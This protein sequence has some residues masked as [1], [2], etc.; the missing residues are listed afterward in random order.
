MSDEKYHLKYL[1]Y[2]T[3][4]LK[5]RLQNGSGG[6]S[7]EDFLK[8]IEKLKDSEEKKKWKELINNLKKI[9][10]DSLIDLLYNYFM[11]NRQIINKINYS[12]LITDDNILD[13]ELLK[14]LLTNEAD[15][16]IDGEEI[17]QIH[18][19]IRSLKKENIS[20]EELQQIYDDIK[21]EI[22]PDFN[23]KIIDLNSNKGMIFST[24]IEQIYQQINQE[25]KENMTKILEIIRKKL[26]E[27]EAYMKQLK[28][29]KDKKEEEDDCLKKIKQE[30][31]KLYRYSN[32]E[33]ILRLDSIEKVLIY[34]MNNTILFNTNQIIQ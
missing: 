13:P 27:L 15:T 30:L 31:I 4:Y 17:Q 33:N 8:E 22:P 6:I 7:I 14:Q 12:K 3:K 24:E 19:K 9:S 5:A 21:K 23:R 1:K 28:Q 2:K 11:F 29:K 20:P 34:A 10:Y 26:E 18:D 32:Q 16:K 25:R